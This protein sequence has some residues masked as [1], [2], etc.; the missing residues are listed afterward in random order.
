MSDATQAN[1][2]PRSV[3]E[4]FFRQIE[5]LGVFSVLAVL[6]IMF[7]QSTEKRQAEQQRIDQTRWEQL[8]AQ[9]REDAQEYRKTI[10]ACCHD[11]LIRLEEAELE[12]S[13]RGD[14]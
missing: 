13:R 3:K 14:R 5:K 10:E 4:I 6:L 11:R 12:R 8:F 7:S 9:Y 1:A 2:S